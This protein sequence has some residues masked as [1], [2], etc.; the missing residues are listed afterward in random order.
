MTAGDAV[1][2]R[3]WTRTAVAATV[4][5][6]L[7]AAFTA[8]FLWWAVFDPINPIEEIRETRFENGPG[9]VRRTQPVRVS[10]VICASREAWGTITA[11]FLAPSPIV[12]APDVPAEG[13]TVIEDQLRHSLVPVP[14]HVLPGCHRRHRYWAIPTTLPP[15]TYT[16]SS[17]VEFCN[18]IGRCVTVELPSPG[19]VEIGGEGWDSGRARQGQRDG[20][21]WRPFDMRRFA[22]R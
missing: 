5:A 21:G 19:D 1:M 3:R 20:T 2:P 16:Y 7:M 8:V 10:R 11:E 13:P 6:L 18:R 9:P 14:I 4:A 17:S 22:S 15:G 12:A